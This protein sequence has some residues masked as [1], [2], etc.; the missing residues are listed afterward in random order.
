MVKTG[1]KTPFTADSASSG[2]GYKDWYYKV[3]KEGFHESQV[4]F[5]ER[6]SSDRYVHFE[7]E[8][9]IQQS[10]V[11]TGA[12]TALERITAGGAFEKRPR[13]SP[14]K[15]WLLIQ[16]SGVGPK[17]TNNAILQKI[18][19]LLGSRVILT[20]GS[21][22]SREGDWLP[23]GSAI[24]FASDK[25]SEYT[26][27]QSLGTSGETALKVSSHPAI[28]PAH[29]PDVSPDGKY[30]A[31]SIFWSKTKNQICVM[32]LDG[33]GLRVYGEGWE[34][35]WSPDSRKLIFTRKVGSYTRIYAM[36]VQTGANLVELCATEANDSCPTWS[37]DGKYI[38]F[39]SD[40]VR[41]RKHLF[42]TRADG[43]VV[44]Q[45]TT[46]HID[47]DSASWGSDGSIYFSANA[48][49]NWDIWKLK[50]RLD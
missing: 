22:D 24:V 36:D 48:G 46:E 42:I 31:F 18:D 2:A 21:S 16:A 50:P 7:L 35:A 37:P 10:V 40:R 20:L 9:I 3:K 32:G 49:E 4:L 44:V 28:G 14:D 26:I 17:A 30:V 8:K 11:L 23:D 27:V 13:L 45:L 5:R 34:P 6:T 41:D 33:S 15:R 39:I 47:I 1:H 19:L 43:Q 38:A 29:Y 12:A 25:L